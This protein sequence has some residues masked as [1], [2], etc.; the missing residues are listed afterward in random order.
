MTPLTMPDDVSNPKS[1][2]QNRQS[3]IQGVLF[4]VGGTIEPICFTLKQIRPQCVAFVCSE[5]SKKQVSIIEDYARDL[6][7]ALDR[8]TFIVSN[9]D[10]LDECVEICNEA[11]SWL[12]RENNLPRES[13]RVDY[14]GGKKNMS[15]AAV[16]SATPYGLRFLYVSGTSAKNGT[17]TVISGTEILVRN[18]NPWD[19]LGTENIRL[20]LRLADQGQFA[21]AREIVGQQ[22]SRSIDENVRNRLGMLDQLLDGLA[23]W[24]AFNHKSALIHWKNGAVPQDLMT[25]AK[26]ANDTIV[27]D[28]ACAVKIAIP[29]VEKLK[30]SYDIKWFADNPKKDDPLLLD[31]I[32]NADR[33]TRQGNCDLAVLL[34]Y[35]VMELNAARRLQ[36]FFQIDNS[37]VPVG[38]MPDKLRATLHNPI[39]THVKL[40]MDNSYKL[41]A[42]RGDSAGKSYCDDLEKWRCMASMR[43]NSWLVHNLQWMSPKGAQYCRDR[44]MKFLDLT[45]ADLPKWPRLLA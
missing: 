12:L 3:E 40:G 21:A 19:Q 43:N 22:R 28:A 4:T 10:K 31:M 38:E 35:R 30:D 6:G 2:I 1:S 17:G 37:N 33:R 42:E 41:L 36:R 9:P 23:N 11:L 5:N 34:Y 44:V 16:L 18:D 7:Y 29:L 13:V 45:D 25:A 24:D 39:N 8:K 14:T 20:A 26:H 32:A 15:A 27:K